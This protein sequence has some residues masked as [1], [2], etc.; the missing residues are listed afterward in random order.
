[1]VP[2]GTESS[3]LCERD[4]LKRS[5]IA[6]AKRTEPAERECDPLRSR[7]IAATF[8]LLMERGYAGASTREI[9]RRARVSKRELYALFDSKEGILAAMIGGRAARMRQPLALP[10]A[11]DRGS[12]VEVLTRFG[13]ALLREG[14]N[15]EV[16]AVIRLAV[17]EAERAPDLARRLN[18]DGRRP[19]RAALVDFIGRVATRGLITG[20]DAETM[21]TQ[22]VALL[23]GDLQMTLLLRLAEAPAPAEIERRAKGAVTALL[24]LYP[25]RVNPVR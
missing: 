17:V 2:Y 14:C 11:V 20:A 19:T 4:D 6:P 1:M 15:P 23:W 3:A 12:V 16:M 8:G 7:I 5:G 22:F 21:A 25:E 18:D 13:V 10:D 9:A 24:S